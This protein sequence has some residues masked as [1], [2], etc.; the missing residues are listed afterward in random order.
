M[1]YQKSSSMDVFGIVFYM[2]ENVLHINDSC[3]ALPF[4][5]FY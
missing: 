5:Y 1:D 4:G 2:G 3:V